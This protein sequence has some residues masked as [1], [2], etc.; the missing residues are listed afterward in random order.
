MNPNARRID[1]ILSDTPLAASLL[2]R[3]AASR[4]AARAIAPV[5]REVSP[6]FDPLRPGACEL[7]AGSLRIHLGSVSHGTKLRQALP[8]MMSA[9]RCNGLEV[10]EIKVCLQPGRL[11]EARNRNGRIS[12]P[13][14]LGSPPEN[15]EKIGQLIAAQ[16]FS[17]KL[18]LTLQSA[19]LRHA[20]ARLGKSIDAKIARMRESEQ[21]LREA[22]GEKRDARAQPAKE[23]AACPTKVALTP[24]QEVGHGAGEDYGPEKEQ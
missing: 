13:G 24:G 1:Q 4:L 19:E 23:Q 17:R 16:I 6:D 12:G 3:V 2:A 22:D 5:C 18:A 21:A 20:V 8:Q 10:I 7:R 15:A 9:L 14:H 11:R